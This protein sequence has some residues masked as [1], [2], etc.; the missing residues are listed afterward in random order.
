MGVT[1]NTFVAFFATFAK[2]AFMLP[3]GEAISQ[4]KWNWY[5]DDRQ[6]S[7]FQLFDSASRGAWGSIL[8]LLRL[9][10]RYFLTLFHFF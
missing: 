2:A 5:S 7:D 8:L 3:L 6:L 9:K 10:H 4:W 1:V